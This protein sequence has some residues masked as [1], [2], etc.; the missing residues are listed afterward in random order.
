MQLITGLLPGGAERL[1]LDMMQLF[2]SHRFDV[3]LVSLVGNLSALEIYGY[4]SKRVDVFDMREGRRLEN[5]LRLRRF[6]KSYSPD[7]VHAHM[8]HSLVVAVAATRFMLRRPAI[9]FTSH[10]NKYPAARV[11]PVRLLKC[12]RDA[13]VI[14]DEAQH[15]EMN[16]ARVRVIANGVHV[17]EIPPARTPWHPSR[18]LRLLAVGRL[19]EQKDPLGLLQT[20]ASADLPEWTLDFVGTGPLEAPARAF[21]AEKGLRERVR[22]LGVRS[23]V[24]QCML[25]ADVFVMHSRREGMPMALLEAGAQAMPVVAT[26]VGSIPEVIGTDRGLLA[27]PEEFADALRRL[28]DDPEAALAAG[29]LLWAHIRGNHSIEATAAAHEHLYLELAEGVLSDA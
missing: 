25:N 8:F 14:F 29:G 20:L 16:V 11:L 12:F 27:R 26:P 24:R 15:P 21:A 13:D 10:L 1:V 18:A 4:P 23:D 9:C 7:V 17:P 19:V 2:D 28:I 22:F 6:I 5:F 3:R